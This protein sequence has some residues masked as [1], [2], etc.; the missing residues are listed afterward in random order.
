MFDWFNITFPNKKLQEMYQDYKPKYTYICSNCNNEFNT[1]SKR[2][3]NEKYC[4]RQCVGRP[5]F[6]LC[7]DFPAH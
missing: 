2:T 7:I 3:T 4:S 6:L 1:N 5:I